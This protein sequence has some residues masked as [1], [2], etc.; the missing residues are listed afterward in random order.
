MM[1]EAPF[2]QMHAYAAAA[3]THVAGGGFNLEPFVL[4]AGVVFHAGSPSP[5]RMSEAL[6]IQYRPS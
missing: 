6:M 3:R 2:A 4:R 1:P 5:L